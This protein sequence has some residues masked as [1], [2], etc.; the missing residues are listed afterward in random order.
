M[1]V[2][3][4]TFPAFA[5]TGAARPLPAPRIW[6]IARTVRQ[7]ICGGLWAKP[8]P[9]TAIIRRVEALVVNGIR[10]VPIWDFQNEVHD[11]HGH[12]VAGAC[13]YDADSPGNIF[14][15]LNSTILGDRP[16]LAASTAA[17][18]LGHA[19]FDGP[20]SVLA[21]RRFFR[22]VIPGERAFETHGPKDEEYWSEYRANEF[23]GGLLTPPDLRI[24]THSGHLFRFDSGH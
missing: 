16:D 13:E 14:L 4:A 17:H 5:E 6:E 12:P 18:E 7:R 15:S 19:I 9:A 3:I 11:E 1:A 10:L 22:V 23:M 2:I 21:C 24:P 20:A 8:L